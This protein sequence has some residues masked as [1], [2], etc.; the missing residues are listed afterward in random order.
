MPFC[1]ELSGR[2]EITQY[3]GMMF[4]SEVAELILIQQKQGNYEYY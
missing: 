2:N 1:I 4:S 3:S